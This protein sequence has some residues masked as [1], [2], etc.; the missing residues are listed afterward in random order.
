VEQGGVG[1]A[2]TGRAGY[3]Q[4]PYQ[5]EPYQREPYQRDPSNWPYQR[6]PYQRDP[7]GSLYQRDPYQR[8]PA[9]SVTSHV[10][11]DQMLVVYTSGFQRSSWAVCVPLTTV[12]SGSFSATRTVPRLRSRLPIPL[13]RATPWLATPAR[14]ERAS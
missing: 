11:G 4:A 14:A 3:S 5:R 7:S 2:L 1:G 13:E 10:S 6:D 9:K 8:E 12:P